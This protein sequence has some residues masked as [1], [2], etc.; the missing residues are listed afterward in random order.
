MN[1]HPDVVAASPRASDPGRRRWLGLLMLGLGLSMIVVD[2][3]IVNVA[4]PSIVGDLKLDGTA[5]EWIVSVYPLVFAALL[6][7]FG[8]LGDSSGGG[9]SS[10]WA[11]ASSASGRS[12]RGSLRAA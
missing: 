3:T 5:A 2:T 11:S 4:V 10:S 8:R 6:I 1:R 7:T 12:S 9:V